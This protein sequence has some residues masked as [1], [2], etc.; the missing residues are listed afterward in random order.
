MV[1]VEKERW[2]EIVET[3][4]RYW[5]LGE[6]CVG[7]ILPVLTEQVQVPIWW[8]ITS[9][10]D[11]LDLIR[12]VVHPI[13]HNRSYPPFCTHLYPPSLFLVPS[14]GI[15]T[16]HKVKFSLSNITCHNHE[17]IPS[18]VFIEHGMYQVQHT[19]ATAF[20][21]YSTHCVQHRPGTVYTKYR[22]H[23]G[24]SLDTLFSRLHVGPWMM[25]QVLA[26]HSTRSTA[27]SKLSMRAEW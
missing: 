5:D 8:V 25:C 11:I 24:V 19:L 22:I 17:A 4:G 15:I 9:I 18:T 13:S 7:I 20:T 23:P 3:I 16:E 10:R 1:N 6:F 12:W 21:K 14:S 27:T 2:E 26:C